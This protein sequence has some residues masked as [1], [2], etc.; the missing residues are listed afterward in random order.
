[1]DE[2]NHVD[3]FTNSIKE[4]FNSFIDEDTKEFI[5]N[6][7]QAKPEEKAELLKNYLKEQ[8]KST[9]KSP[10]IKYNA[11]NADIDTLVEQKREIENKIQD[12]SEEDANLFWIK[13]HKI[14][15]D[16]N[17]KIDVLTAALTTLNSNINE[18]FDDIN[19]EI[20][21]LKKYIGNNL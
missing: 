20:T 10:I 2:K 21:I 14:P 4:M 18:K 5:N 3:L 7:S 1:M 13:Y 8:Q 6:M 15:N 12:L 17:E 19:T 9:C 16:T 11:E